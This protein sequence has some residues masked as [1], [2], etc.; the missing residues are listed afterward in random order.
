MQWGLGQAPN[1]DF[2]TKYQN[3]AIAKLTGILSIMVITKH[4][5]NDL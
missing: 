4:S 3:L 5:D 1:Q 2:G